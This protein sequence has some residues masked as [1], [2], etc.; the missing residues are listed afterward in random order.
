[1]LDTSLHEANNEL[2][3]FRI[4][5]VDHQPLMFALDDNQPLLQSLQQRVAANKVCDAIFFAVSVHYIILRQ[6]CFCFCLL[7]NFSVSFL[8]FSAHE[9]ALC[10]SCHYKSVLLRCNMG[11][12]P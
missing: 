12:Q 9:F 1:M 6:L 3:T 4:K 5:L 8:C 11:D 10:F 2:E 7:V